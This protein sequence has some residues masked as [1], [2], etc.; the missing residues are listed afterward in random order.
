MCFVRINGETL[1]SHLINI[2]YR[3]IMMVLRLCRIPTI[4]KLY[5][6]SKSVKFPFKPDGFCVQTQ[7]QF[8]L[9]VHLIRF[10]QKMISESTLGRVHFTQGVILSLLYG[11]FICTAVNVIMLKALMLYVMLE[12]TT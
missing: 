10:L 2:K 6:Y 12:I 3:E 9:S 1:S 4:Q 8:D 7:A 5:I 11:H